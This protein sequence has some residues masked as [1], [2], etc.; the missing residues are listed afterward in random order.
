[1][2]FNGGISFFRTSTC[3]NISDKIN[4]SLPK[5]QVKLA[6]THQ[7]LYNCYNLS[8]AP[9]TIHKPIFFV[10][11]CKDGCLSGRLLSNIFG[12]SPCTSRN[13]SFINL[14]LNCSEVTYLNVKKPPPWNITINKY[15][16]YDS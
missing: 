5:T 2:Y 11:I 8:I 13:T 3:E 10:G 15:C 1:M 6:L 9:K 14:F 16:R 7:C 4:W 12:I